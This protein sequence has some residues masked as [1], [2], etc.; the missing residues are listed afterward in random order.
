LKPL[1]YVDPYLKIKDIDL[2]DVDEEMD[3]V[4][5]TKEYTTWWELEGNEEVDNG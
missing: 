5:I 3:A 1:I 4:G 2:E